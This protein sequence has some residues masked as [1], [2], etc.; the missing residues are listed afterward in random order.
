MISGHLFLSHLPLGPHIYNYA[1]FSFS[2]RVQ[3]GHNEVRHIKRAW[4]QDVPKSGLKGIRLFFLSILLTF[5]PF[6]EKRGTRKYTPEFIPT[7][8]KKK[9]K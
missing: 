4:H 3:N 2:S 7:Q 1:Q 5:T 9:R 6:R 8:G